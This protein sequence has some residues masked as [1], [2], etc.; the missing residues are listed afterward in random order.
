M[1]G[2]STL[3]VYDGDILS[4]ESNLIVASMQYRVGA[5]GFLYLGT[6][7]APGNV[8]LFDQSLALKWLKNNIAF[9][10]GNPNSLTVFGESAGASSVSVHFLSPYRCVR[11]T[12]YVSRQ[13]HTILVKAP[14]VSR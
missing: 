14:P 8:G 13:K 2:T 7:D 4:V 1:S 9:F 3:E 12:W 10:G 6:S 5:F 11:I